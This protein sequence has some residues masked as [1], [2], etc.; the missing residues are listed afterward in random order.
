MTY[1][2]VIFGATGDLTHRKLMP[3]FYNL[4]QQGQLVDNIS[5]ISIGRREKD[6]QIYR[7]EVYQSVQKYSRFELGEDT[8]GDFAEK[9]NYIC[10]DFREEQGYELL[11]KAL[12]EEAEHIYYLAVSPDYFGLIVD[13]LKK[14]KLAGVDFSGS[15]VVIEKPFGRDLESARKLNDKISTAFPEENIYRID[16]YL[17]KEMLQNIMVIRFA[18]SLFEPLWNNRYIENIQIISSESAGVGERGSYYEKAGALRDM[19]QNHMMQLLALTAMEP[20]VDMSTESIRNE[21]IKVLKALELN[22]D[23]IDEFAVRGQY[24]KGEIK[25][26]KVP[27]YRDEERTAEDSQTETFVALKIIINNLRWSGVPF[28][29]KTGKRLTHKSTEVVVEFK[30]RAHPAYLKSYNDLAPDLLVIRIQP[31]EGLFFQFNA[32]K[33]GTDNVI[34]PVQ[35]DYCQNCQLGDNS[36]EAYERLIYDIIRGDSTLFTH[37]HEL[38]NSWHF[39][40]KIAE[41]WAEGE[42]QIP[43]YSAGS[44][45]P[46]AANRML[47]RDGRRWWKLNDFQGEHIIIDSKGGR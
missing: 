13:R 3:A 40:D 4:Y 21:K 39:I 33:P 16:H 36:P 15:R 29:I 42:A 41:K 30:K 24:G 43:G 8:W 32:K 45:G 35:M 1:Q 7:K 38:G 2:F 14:Y 27:S 10:F 17:G 11:K 31:Q 20:P 9:I 6:N 37:W 18:N 19:V 12:D 5:I 44:D 26:R 28:Y 47:E 25:G 46:E 23:R 34:V 22:F